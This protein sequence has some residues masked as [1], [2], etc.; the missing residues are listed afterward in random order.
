[1]DLVHTDS[2]SFAKSSDFHQ[3]NRTLIL[4]EKVI[5]AAVNGP[6]V[7][8]SVSTPELYDLVYS[9]PDAYLFTPFVKQGMATEGA[10]SFSFPFLMGHQRAAALFLAGERITAQ[11]AR[12]LGLINKIFP[13]DT[14]FP[15]VMEIAESLSRSPPGSLKATKR[16]MKEPVLQRLL[17]VNNREYDIIHADRYGFGEYKEAVNKFEFEQQQKAKSRSKI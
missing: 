4:S 16:L 15:S 3:L 6:A 9:V 13:K 14:F 2:M 17:D 8:Y 11:E 5:I 1:M 10:S 7:G 12:D